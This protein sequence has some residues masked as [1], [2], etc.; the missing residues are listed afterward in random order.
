[1]KDHERTPDRGV[2]LQVNVG[3][4]VDGTAIVKTP[5]DGAVRVDADGLAGDR[6]ANTR[7]H[8]RPFQAVYAYGRASYDWWEERLGRELP[9][10][11]FGENLT[12]TLDADRALLGEQWRLGTA[13]VRVESPRI[14]CG[15]LTARV[16]EPGFAGTFMRS[17]RPGSYLSVVEPGHVAAGDDAVVVS[18]PDHD[19]TVADV[20][21]VWAATGRER[22]E[23]A[24]RILAV[25]EHLD[26]IVVAELERAV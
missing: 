21:G 22:A 3:T 6:V 1:M 14:P 19:H 4:P 26:P 13:L 15:T 23:A 12:V 24:R 11:L 17:G 18:R 5:V 8:G 16:G 20:L 7:H 10:G 9:S 25:R 2:V